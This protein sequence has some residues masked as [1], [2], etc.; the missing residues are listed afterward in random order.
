M[1]ICVVFTCHVNAVKLMLLHHIECN[2]LDM[3]VDAGLCSG[4]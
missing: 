1:A 3:Q 2:M 4:Q